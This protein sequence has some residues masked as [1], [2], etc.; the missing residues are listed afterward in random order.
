MSG[1]DSMHELIEL[2]RRLGIAVRHAHL[3]GDGGGMAVVKGLRQLF[4]D[5]DASPE[6]QLGRTAGALGRLND[7]E[8]V[9]IRPDLRDLLERH[10]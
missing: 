5:L 4:I 8:Q 1:D 3:G 7:L 10:A 9:F 6:D 2:A